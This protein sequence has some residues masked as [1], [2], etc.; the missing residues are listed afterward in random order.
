MIYLIP[1]K[2]AY[3]RETKLWY[4]LNFQLANKK[5]GETNK[6]LVIMNL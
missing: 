3:F 5:I 2:K 6:E 4:D 1:L